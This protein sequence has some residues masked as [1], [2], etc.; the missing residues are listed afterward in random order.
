VIISD[1]GISSITDDLEKR[2]KTQTASRTTGYA[3]LE[4]FSGIISPKMDYY[5]LGIS[6]WN[7]SQAK[8]PSSLKTAS[9]RTA[10]RRNSRGK[11]REQR[12]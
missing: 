6:L 9:Y 2:H 11:F 10:N 3:A 5:A 8:T 1:F 7:S 4:V 12:Q